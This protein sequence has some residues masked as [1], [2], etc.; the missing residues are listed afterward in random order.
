MLSI[1]MILILSTYLSS[2]VTLGGDMRSLK[3]ASSRRFN[4]IS[5]PPPPG[6]KKIKKFNAKVLA[7]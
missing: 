5:R 7:I 6:N 3:P 1:V 2:N 4:G